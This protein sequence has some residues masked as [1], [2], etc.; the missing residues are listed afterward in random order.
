MNQAEVIETWLGS[1]ADAVETA[2]PQR[3]EV[4]GRTPMMVV[5]LDLYRSLAGYR[6]AFIDMLGSFEVPV[7]ELPGEQTPFNLAGR[8]VPH[9]F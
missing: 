4:V 5:S 8:P 3:L 6:P 1:L 9:K 2:G 7:T